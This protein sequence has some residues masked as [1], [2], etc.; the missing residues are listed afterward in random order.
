MTNCDV[1]SEKFYLQPGPQPGRSPAPNTCCAL[2]QANA[3]EA[4]GAQAELPPHN[5]LSFRED[6]QQLSW[7]LTLFQERAQEEGCLPSLQKDGRTAVL[8]KLMRRVVRAI[9][10]SKLLGQEVLP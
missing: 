2:G 5:K 10:P 8:G 7:F 9:V 6:V 1:A 4:R 3:S